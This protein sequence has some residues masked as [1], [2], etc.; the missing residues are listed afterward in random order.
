MDPASGESKAIEWNVD[1]DAVAFM[2]CDVLPVFVS[3]DVLVDFVRTFLVMIGV[4]QTSSLS[5]VDSI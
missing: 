4:T 2:T 3:V 5:I 1:E